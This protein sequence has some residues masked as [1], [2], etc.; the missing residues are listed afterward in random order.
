MRPPFL[1]EQAHSADESGEAGTNYRSR[2]V[3]K[4]AREPNMLHDFLYIFS[5]STFA[6]EHEKFVLPGLIPTLGGPAIIR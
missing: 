3:R 6:G 5:R 4:G 1:G 2:E